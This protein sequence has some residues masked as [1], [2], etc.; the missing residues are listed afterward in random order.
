M[1]PA[2]GFY[3]HW[4]STTRNTSLYLLNGGSIQPLEKQISSKGGQ[5]RMEKL[6]QCPQCSKRFPSYCNYCDVDGTQLT[7]G[8]TVWPR[9]ARIFDNLAAWLYVGAGLRS[10]LAIKALRLARKLDPGNP[11][12][13]D[14]S[15]LAGQAPP[16][17]QCRCSECREI[18]TELKDQFTRSSGMFMS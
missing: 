18:E 11:D 17:C 1:A 10:D 5:G 14:M 8:R 13:E 2:N 6:N 3:K 12:S 4:P 15:S 9:L 16:E 7:L